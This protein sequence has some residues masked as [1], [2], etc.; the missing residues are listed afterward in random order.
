MKVMKIWK[1]LMIMKFYIDKKVKAFTGRT[2]TK[3]CTYIIKQ[4]RD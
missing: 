2:K 3:K 4:F 1:V